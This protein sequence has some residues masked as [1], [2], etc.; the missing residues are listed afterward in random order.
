M[1][2]IRRD[3][4][5]GGP[6]GLTWEHAGHVVEVDDPIIATQLVRI[7]GG[8]FSEVIPA[9]D[10]TFDEVDDPG[11]VVNPEP[12]KK[13]RGRPR[14]NVTPGTPIVE[15]GHPEQ[16]L[17]S[18][19]G[20]DISGAPHAGEPLEYVKNDNRGKTLA[21]NPSADGRETPMVAAN[22]EAAEANGARAAS[23]HAIGV[24]AH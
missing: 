19:I 20:H 1:A 7:P 13:R 3:R 5:G 18:P 12:P 23:R 14:K 6:N 21:A 24:Q 17:D 9:D 10:G 8:G 4:P 15:A 16:Q 22:A 11:F 2:H